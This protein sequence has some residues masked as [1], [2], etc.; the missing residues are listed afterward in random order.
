MD[1][2]LI[3]GNVP[4]DEST[5]AQILSNF[6]SINL[7]QTLAITSQLTST[8]LWSMQRPTRDKAYITLSILYMR[9]ESWW[10]YQ[11]NLQWCFFLD[12]ILGPTE[13]LHMMK[14]CLFSDQYVTAVYNY[15]A[16]TSHNLV[17]MFHFLVVTYPYLNVMSRHF[18]WHYIR[19]IEYD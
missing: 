17:V 15:K 4:E 9:S 12:N 13:V 7:F 3:F 14:Y 5:Q 6:L 10:Y 1:F 8:F 19:L 16:I 18:S 11:K 2:D